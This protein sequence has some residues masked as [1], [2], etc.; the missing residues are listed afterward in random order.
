MP[1][2]VLVILQIG[3]QASKHFAVQAADEPDS[4]CQWC[5]FQAGVSRDKSGH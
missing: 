1:V 4:S 2:E 5:V 3:V